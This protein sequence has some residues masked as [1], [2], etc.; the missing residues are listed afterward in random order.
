MLKLLNHWSRGVLDNTC[1]E[2]NNDLHENIYIDDR[3]IL[4]KMGCSRFIGQ[5]PLPKYSVRLE[6]PELLFLAIHTNAQVHIQSQQK[7]L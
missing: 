2:N 5:E 3:F 4:S 1:S 7:R 6:H